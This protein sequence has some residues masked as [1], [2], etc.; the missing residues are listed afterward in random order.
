M[1]A[2]RARRPPSAKSRHCI[3][4]TQIIVKKAAYGPT[5]AESKTPPQR[6]PDEPVPGMVKLII[7]AAKT[8]APITPMRGMSLSLLSSFIFLIEQTAA[9]A[10][11]AY[12]TPA[13]VGASSA[14]AI[15]MDNPSFVIVWKYCYM[16]LPRMLHLLLVYHLL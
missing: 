3:S 5:T 1:L 2:P 14:S 10:E 13:T 4:S 7:C 9:P 12:I 15:C 8:K 16:L 11:Q 6:W